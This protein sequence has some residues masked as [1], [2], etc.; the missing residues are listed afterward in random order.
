[1]GTDTEPEVPEAEAAASEGTEVPEATADD[2][3]AE[4][5]STTEGTS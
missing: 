4:T 1:V 3:T 2:T 5:D